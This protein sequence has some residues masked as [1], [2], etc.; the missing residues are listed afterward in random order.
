MTL[1]AATLVPYGRDGRIDPQLLRAHALWVLGHG[2]EGFAPLTLE[3]PW[4]RPPEKEQVLQ[5]L[6]D[7]AAGRPLLPNVWDPDPNVAVRLA[8]VAVGAGAKAVLLPPPLG[9]AVTEDGVVAWYRVIA[10]AVG[11]PTLAW[12]APRYAPEPS[13]RLLRRLRTEAG[14]AGLLDGYGEVARLRRLAQEWPERLWAADDAVLPALADTPGL[15][16]CLSELANL[17]PELARRLFRG[18]EEGLA[19]AWSDR[20]RIVE[21][22]GGIPAMKRLLGVGARIPVI[23]ADEAVL[24]QLPAPSFR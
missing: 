4:L 15:V 11:V 8:Q 10:R 12:F 24:R 9:H 20:A 2:V 7:V 21:R 22:A 3:F 18:G 6:G 1:L 14:I 5:V 17:Y 23:G 19:A 16:G 13:A